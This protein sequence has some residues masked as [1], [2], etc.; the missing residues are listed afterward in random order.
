MLCELLEEEGYKAQWTS[1]AGTA[2]DIISGCDISGSAIRCPDLVLLDLTMQG[3]DPLDMARRL[4]QVVQAAPAIIV[5]SARPTAEVETAARSINA[6]G[7][8]RKPF[9]IDTLLDLV[10]Q[11]LGSKVS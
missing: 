1:N 6:V 9:Q 10:E 3:L 7:V 8:V 11:A 5:L 2:L 4:P